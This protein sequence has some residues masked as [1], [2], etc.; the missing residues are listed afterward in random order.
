MKPN[1][2]TNQFKIKKI[3]SHGFQLRNVSNDYSRRIFYHFHSIDFDI[4]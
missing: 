4:S 3:T 1:I 2:V